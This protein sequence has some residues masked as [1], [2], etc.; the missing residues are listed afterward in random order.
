MA[1]YNNLVFINVD[2]LRLPGG[3]GFT[4]CAILNF[5]F[6]FS[7]FFPAENSFRCDRERKKRE[8]KEKIKSGRNPNWKICVAKLKNQSLKTKQTDEERRKKPHLQLRNCTINHN[9]YFE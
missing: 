6:R 7:Y 4:Q 1:P 8:E 9:C 5:F 2:Y 3:F